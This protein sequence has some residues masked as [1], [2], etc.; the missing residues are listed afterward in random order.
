MFKI[1]FRNRSQAFFVICVL[2]ILILT[3][4]IPGWDEGKQLLFA[5]DVESSYEPITQ[6][7]PLLPIKNIPK[8][9]AQRMTAP[10]LIG[11]IAWTTNVD[12]RLIYFALTLVTMLSI[13]LIFGLLLKELRVPLENFWLFYS[14]LIL[15]PYLFRYYLIVPG[16]VTDLL[17]VLFSLLTLLM[18]FREKLVGM[19]FFLSGALLFRQT[20]VMLLPPLVLYFFASRK[21]ISQFV[22]VT[23]SV[24][25]TVAIV[26]SLLNLVSQKF[27]H[28]S[29]NNVAILTA[30][31]SY[32]VSSNHSYIELIEFVLRVF[33]P[34]AGVFACLASIVFLK[35]CNIWD[36]K[37]IFLFL[38]G[39]CIAL[40]PLMTG[41]L[42]TGKNAGRLATLGLIPF[43]LSLSLVLPKIEL[44]RLFK[45]IFL[46]TLA[47]GSLHHLYTNPSL[48]SPIQFVVVQLFCCLMIL[49]LFIIQNL[50]TNS[51]ALG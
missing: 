6:A 4:R 36:K 48:N 16:M 43:I 33:I 18:L 12:Y 7:S 17:F 41:P 30:F 39:F 51:K 29:D 49:C 25:F 14:F 50:K 32:I 23:L 37:F 46:F 45:F 24:I 8:H 35:K 2:A 20:M 31:Y 11:L 9:H 21:S 40:Q 44:S 1:L 5:N 22:T 13:L 34:F 26:Y 27:T 38:C 3:N 19:L 28:E 42:L 10:Y 15:H 47:V